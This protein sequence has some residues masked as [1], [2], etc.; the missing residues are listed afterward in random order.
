MRK[1]R[2]LYILSL[3]MLATPLFTGCAES[4]IDQLTEQADYQLTL[5]LT[6]PGDQV[7]TRATEDGVDAFNENVINR[8]DIFL[9]PDGQTDQDAVWVQANAPH[10]YSSSNRQSTV[11]TINMN[12]STFR[13]LFPNYEGSNSPA[14]TCTVYALVNRPSDVSLPEHT[15]V[16]SLNALQL[17]STTFDTFTADGDV[18]TNTIPTDFV[19]SGMA[20]DIE[21]SA[22]KKHLTGNVDVYR[23]AAKVSLELT[24][25]ADRVQSDD[26]TT[27]YVPDLSSIRVELING[28]KKGY[29][30]QQG[31]SVSEDGYFTKRD[32]RMRALTAAEAGAEGH[33]G[34]DVPFYTYPNDWS[35]DMEHRSYLVVVIRW[36]PEG[37]STITPTYYEIP[38]NDADEQL[39]RNTHYKI[40]M[41]I[42]VIGGLTPEESV[43]L[44]TCSYIILP[45]GST[46]QNG[47]H[48]LEDVKVNL[49]R[50]RYLAVAESNIVMDNITSKQIYF[51]SSNDVE[52]VNLKL[53]QMSLKDTNAAWESKWESS[54]Y[55]VSERPF[56]VVFKTTGDGA[57]YMLVEHELNNRMDE[58][59]D[60]TDYR[61]TFR[62]QHSEEGYQDK[63]Y[64]DITIIQHPMIYASAEQ[65]SY[66][67]STDAAN[68]NT[69]INNARNNAGFGGSHGLTGNNK[70]PNRYKIT[71]SALTTD[72]YVIGDPRLSVVNNALTGNYIT[73]ASTDVANWTAFV[74]RTNNNKYYDDKTRY[75]RTNYW[76][77]VYYTENNN[78]TY[79]TLEFYHPA[80]ESAR[81]RSMLS[82]QYMIASSYGVTTAITKE[83]ARKRCASYQE[84]GYPAGRW[85]L[86]TSGEVEYCV[87]LSAW[88]YI[89]ILFGSE[90]SE[91]TYWS[92][93]GSVTVTYDADGSNG[94]LTVNETAN[95]NNTYYVRCVYDTWYWNGD[96][97]NKNTFTWGDRQQ[98]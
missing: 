29:V 78:G 73:G 80:E 10:T 98:F 88:G 68:G 60:Y 5:S 11:A 93:N 91:T 66:Y 74:S 52:I 69:F 39:Q 3:I 83:N 23:T 53:E 22:D 16:A 40:K 54:T 49:K 27:W 87:Q 71:A 97:C 26:G 45:W 41:D 31:L 77:N 20:T 4:D 28:V 15:D 37:T 55:D 92:A 48:E 25:V 34:M 2:F 58:T 67:P 51:S 35:Q 89:P 13:E 84:D 38:I 85:R 30:N 17:T 21:L 9:Y 33:F 72:K 96:N 6:L 82:P 95:T 47:G 32:I 65:N 42:G 94:S 76:G 56:N 57:T 63:Y 18:K 7:K 86:P 62:I 8:V 19:M 70:N 36:T 64:Q 61:I 14:Q 81:T 24:N 79:C 12:Y 50:V 75:T 46:T 43:T 59:S 44:N 1:K 90:G